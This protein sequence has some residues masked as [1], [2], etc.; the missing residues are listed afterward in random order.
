M[1]FQGAL[2][3]PTSR[4]TPASDIVHGDFPFTRGMSAQPESSNHCRPHRQIC[5][6]RGRKA[7]LFSQRP[8]FSNPNYDVLLIAGAGCNP[9]A[10]SSCRSIAAADCLLP[11][12]SNSPPC[13]CPMRGCFL[14]VS[15]PTSVSLCLLSSSLSVSLFVCQP[16]FMGV[17]LFMYGY[18]FRVR[19]LIVSLLVAV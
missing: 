3:Q 12:A 15:V 2:S 18:S 19:R 14:S 6:Q 1:L 4:P 17:S 13:H 8:F 11:W 16:V 10:W 5:P 9:I 7:V